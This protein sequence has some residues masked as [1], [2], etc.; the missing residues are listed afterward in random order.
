MEKDMQPW[1]AIM[2]E[3]VAGA[4]GAKKGKAKK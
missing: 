3:V 1:R 2:N 4:K